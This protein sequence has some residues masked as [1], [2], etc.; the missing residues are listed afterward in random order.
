MPD[1]KGRRTEAYDLVSALKA[2][3]LVEGIKPRSTK[4][5]T[6]AARR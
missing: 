1:T 2:H 5:I 6:S 3:T 4:N